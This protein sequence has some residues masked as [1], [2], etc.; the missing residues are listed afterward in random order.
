M[1]NQK[2][3]K[4]TTHIALI[5]R[6]LRRNKIA[7]F[8]FL[9]IT[10]YVV[11][12]IF[13]PVLAPYDPTEQDLS[14]SLAPMSSEHWLGCDDF[15]RDIL[16]RIIYGA[17]TSLI[18]QLTS[19][20]IALFVGVFLGAVGG[21]FGGWIDEVIMRFMDIMLAFPGMLL[22]LAIVAMLG[23]NLTNLIIAI[24]IYSVPQF[25]RIT[26][27]SVISVKQ[28]DYVTAARAIGETDNSI[29]WHYVLPNAIS[30]IIVQT[31]LRM[32]TV[33]LTAAGLGFLG[34]GVQ[35]PTAEWG[36][37]LSSARIYL[38]SAPHVAIIPGLCIM[39]VVLGFNFLG[40]GL[41]DA[42]NPRL[43]E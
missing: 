26:R 38:R 41:Q 13:A 10:L 8:G 11:A 28:N 24:G 25:A 36:T 37:M 27:G 43:K 17:R 6:R 30:P 15:G 2:T 1:A 33:L 29:I 21:Y 12:A 14:L 23:P 9:L 42:L 5:W 40:D 39:L 4:S 31:S 16:S 34:L 35:P 32:A 22:A 7:V 19:V 20:V 3:R 18:I